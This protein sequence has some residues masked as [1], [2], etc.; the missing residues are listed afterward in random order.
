MREYARE[1][2]SKLKENPSMTN[3]GIHEKSEMF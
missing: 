2:A 1:I 3:S